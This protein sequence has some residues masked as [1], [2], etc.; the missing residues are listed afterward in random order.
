MSIRVPFSA[1]T[2][3]GLLALAGPVAAQEF[4]GTYVIDSEDGTFTLVF[5]QEGSGSVQG[6]LTGG[7]LQVAFMGGREDP[8]ISGTASTA[9]GETYGFVAQLE[10]EL[11]YLKL[12]PF[13]YAGNPAYDYAE[14]LIFARSSS[15]AGAAAQAAPAAA[16]AWAPGAETE[17]SV[18][19]NR[20]KLESEFVQQVERQYGTLIADG[21]YWYDAK[22]GAWGV[23]GGPTLGFIMAN[24]ELPGPMPEDISGGGTSIFFNGREIHLQDQQALQQ[25][26]GFTVPGRYWLD[27]QGNLGVEGNNYPIANLAAAVQASQG[28][29]YGSVTGA[30]G[31]AAS[32]GQG[33]YMFSGR[34]TSGKSVFWYSGQ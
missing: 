2:L 30:G 22:C 3:L 25:I 17:R 20:T 23:E 16:A 21:R 34:D 18:Y 15:E 11:L 5:Q 26:F 8:G 31:T 12:F 27:A 33:G 7:G 13:D 19:I 1:I 4:T 28:S 9:T 14:T 29:Q 32:D 6:Q 10:G 24:L